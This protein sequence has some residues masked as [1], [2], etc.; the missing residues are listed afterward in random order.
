MVP[1]EL[2]NQMVISPNAVWHTSF[3]PN[4]VVPFRFDANVSSTNRQNMINAMAVWENVANVDFRSRSGQRNYVHIRDS[5]V[6]SSYVGMQGGEQIINISDWG[7]HFVI[8]HELGHALG[9]WHE[10]SRLDRDHYVVIEWPCIQAGMAHNFEKRD[11]ADVYPKRAYGLVDASTY[12]FDSVMHY[13]S[14]AFFS[15]ANPACTTTRTITVLPPNEAWQNRIGQLAHLSTLDALTMAFLYPEAGWR[16]VDR[17][18]TG[19]SQTGTFIEPYQNF[20]D[21]LPHV[22]DGG[23]LWVQPGTYAASG[24]RYNI[25]L[26]I[27]AP[28]GHV[29]LG[30]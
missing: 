27:R 1:T 7:Q 18:D 19:S 28:L 13:H 5:S 6:N 20:Y 11:S 2:Y 21:S 22:P 8:V 16:F 30:R 15:N 4:G 17:T 10:Q 3:W 29:I 25:N 24:H 9:L 26:T 23:T 12:D 14:T